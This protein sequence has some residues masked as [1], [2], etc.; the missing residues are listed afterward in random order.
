MRISDM[1]DIFAAQ[2]PEGQNLTV[3]WYRHKRY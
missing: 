2:V 1:L 3:Q